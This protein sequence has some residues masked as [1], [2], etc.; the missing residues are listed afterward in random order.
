[1]NVSNC[2][3]QNFTAAFFLEK[4]CLRPKK[5]QRPKQVLETLLVAQLSSRLG[6]L[7]DL[8]L[9]QIE[10]EVARMAMEEAG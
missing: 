9:G 3:G 1:M 7:A 10:E 5:P 8:S 2:K 4:L 6:G